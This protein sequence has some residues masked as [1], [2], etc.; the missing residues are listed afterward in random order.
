MPWEIPT[1]YM[2]GLSQEKLPATRELAWQRF[3]VEA[4]GEGEHGAFPAGTLEGL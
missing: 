4:S 2:S 3:A 1:D